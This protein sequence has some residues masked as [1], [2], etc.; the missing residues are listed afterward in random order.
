MLGF[1]ATVRSYLLPFSFSVCCIASLFND[2][3]HQDRTSPLW[4]GFRGRSVRCCIALF[5]LCVAE[6]IVTVGLHVDYC[7]VSI[8]YYV[9]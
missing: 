6:M 4:N 2:S 1:D 9:L 8:P 3:R 5:S 7:N